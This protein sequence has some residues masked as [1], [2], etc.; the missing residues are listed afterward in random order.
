L[1]AKHANYNVD[2]AA[3]QCLHAA[4]VSDATAA[5]AAALSLAIY[6]LRVSAAA[7]WATFLSAA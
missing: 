6:R 2:A 5:A 7:L 1:S 4:A 3:R